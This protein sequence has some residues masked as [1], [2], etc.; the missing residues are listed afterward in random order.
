LKEVVFIY[1]PL[2]SKR[3]DYVLD[4]VFKSKGVD[5]KVIN[6]FEKFE[7][8]DGY[9]INYSHNTTRNALLSFPVEGILFE[10]DIRKTSNLDHISN[11]DDWILNDVKDPFSV[12]F[13]ML[14]CYEE[15][16][17]HS[18]DE[19][20]R[21]PAK[22]SSIFKAKRLNKPNVDL[23]VKSIW[24]SL[25][26]DYKNVKNLYKETITFDIDSAWGIKNKSLG[27][28]ILGD[29][30][31]FIKGESL[32]TRFDI[33][34]NKQKDPFDTFD[35]IKAIAKNHHVICFFLLG[36]WSKYDKNTNWKN[37]EFQNL[38]KNLAKSVDIA[39]HPSYK[40]Y[41]DK[42]KIQTEINRL[43]TINGDQIIKSRQHFLKLTIPKTCILL[44][45]LGIQ[46]DYSMGFADAY[47]FRAGTCFSYKFFNLKSNSISNLKI[48]PITYMDGTLN[49]YMNLNIESS[50]KI[51]DNLKSEIK[52]VGGHFIPLWHNETINNQGIWKDWVK[53]FEKNF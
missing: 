52:N 32:Q 15:H 7:S 33:R 27:R 44:E 29:T 39:I 25:N 35:Y 30:K 37:I 43:E 8:I 2:N 38:I 20:G 5:Y 10:K 9:K 41:L 31:A 12:I 46:E 28:R 18:R 47:G 53:V 40:S 3:L 16:Y 36:N 6:S 22:N 48:Y 13:F 42:G 26:I 4:F 19:H 11:S 49:Q 17:I 51:I 14:T 34:R 23:L 50:I 21:F 24:I 1:S 45:Q